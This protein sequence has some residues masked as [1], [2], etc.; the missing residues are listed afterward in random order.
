[1]KQLGVLVMAAVLVI[2]TVSPAHAAGFA[3]NGGPWCINLTNFCD[4]INISTSSGLN[5]GFWDFTCADNWIVVFGGNASPATTVG[6]TATGSA[7][8]F[9]WHVGPM[10]FDLY[11]T[12]GFGV[13]LIQSNQPFTATPGKCSG[14]PLNGLEPSLGRQ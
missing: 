8:Q 12:D 10:T 6:S 11:A 5:Y 1:M 14:S 4:R 3:P 13:F 7:A 9:V 2:G